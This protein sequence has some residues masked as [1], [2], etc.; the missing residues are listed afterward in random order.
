MQRSLVDV[1]W[2]VEE[3]GLNLRPA[4]VETYMEG[5]L[6]RA[7]GGPVRRINAICATQ[8]RSSRFET[9]LKTSED[10]FQR[11]GRPT[12]VKVLSMGDDIDGL[13]EERGY[14][15]EGRSH[16]LLAE[17]TAR[18]PDTSIA[19]VQVGN[20]DNEWFDAWATIAKP[21]SAE[22][23]SVFENSMRKIV[24]PK[25]YAAFKV[26]GQIVSMAYGVL[27]QGRLG[28]DAVAT[29]SDHRG[30]GYARLVVSALQDWANGKGVRQSCLSVEADNTPALALYRSCGFDLHVYDYH[31]RVKR[32]TTG[33]VV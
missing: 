5:W 28:V 11:L 29:R 4:P 3:V 1:A 33:N 8:F 2:Q 27:H 26:G 9:V 18:S 19:K 6:I 30:C 7:S 23:R 10:L 21:M 31:Y 14:R 12:I 13:L 16:V 22:A 24:L 15:S 17:H 20:A 32:S 25:V